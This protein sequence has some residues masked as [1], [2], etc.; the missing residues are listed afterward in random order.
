MHRYLPLSRY[1]CSLASQL[2]NMEVGPYLASQLPDWLKRYF[3]CTANI[4]LNSPKCTNTYH[5]YQKPTPHCL[6]SQLIN[7][8]PASSLINIELG[9]GIKGNYRYKYLSKYLVSALVPILA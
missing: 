9:F 4:K 1:L 2:I 3:I 5:L 8:K 6:A 7:I